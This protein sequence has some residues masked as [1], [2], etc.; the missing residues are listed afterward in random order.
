V[1]EGAKGKKTMPEGKRCRELS[2]ERTFDRKKKGTKGKVKQPTRELLRKK[3][4]RLTTGKQDRKLYC[5][6]SF[7]AAGPRWGKRPQKKKAGGG[8]AEGGGGRKG[9]KK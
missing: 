1:K 5:T 2:P 7:K 8:K 6:Q 4:K 3:K 9:K